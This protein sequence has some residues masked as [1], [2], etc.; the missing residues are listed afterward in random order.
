[1]VHRAVHPVPAENLLNS[2]VVSL[3]LLAPGYVLCFLYYWS[4]GYLQVDD[5]FIYLRIAH[6]MMVGLGPVWNSGDAFTN[7]T[8][9]LWPSLI[10]VCGSVFGAAKLPIISKSLFYLC[11]CGAS[12]FLYLLLK[13]SKAN[14]LAWIA[15]LAIFLPGQ[16]I[17]VIGMETALALLTVLGAIWAYTSNRSLYLTAIFLGLFYLTRAEGI[18]F[19]TL[20]VADY[21][22]FGWY[23]RRREDTARERLIA[24]M[25][26]GL[27]CLGLAA[28]WHVY[29][30]AFTGT[31]F[32]AT[33][34]A[35]MIQGASG[36]FWEPFAT[37]IVSNAL[38]A[39]RRNPFIVVLAVFGAGWLLRATPLIAWWTAIHLC[40]YGA[41]QVAAYGWYYYPLFF[42]MTLA[43]FLGFGQV[44]SS[45]LRFVQD[46][47]ASKKLLEATFTLLA[48]IAL[49][50]LT[51]KSQT[52]IAHPLAW[53]KDLRLHG[54][55]DPA[56]DRRRAY[57]QVSEWF[58]KDR[59][60]TRGAAILTDEIGVLGYH[61]REW[62]IVDEIGLTDPGFTNA[63]I[64]DWDYYVGHFAPQFL[65]RNYIANQPLI[66]N[67]NVRGERYVS[68]RKVF[69]ADSPFPSQIYERQFEY[70]VMVPRGFAK[71][72]E[73]VSKSHYESADFGY[74][75][76]E[77]YRNIDHPDLYAFVNTIMPK[78]VLPTPYEVFEHFVRDGTE[79]I[80]TGAMPLTRTDEWRPGQVIRHVSI[81]ELAHGRYEYFVGL[82]DRNAR[83]RLHLPGTGDDRV[84]VGVFHLGE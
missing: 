63:R 5:A 48:A 84:R 45:A 32:P 38:D 34:N 22:G 3:V 9:G 81:H 82:Y 18:L 65:V 52:A 71:R 46:A 36:T 66:L 29:T 21:L 24:L 33:L 54:F 62:K 6:N 79:F 69:T 80:P 25:G 11:L 14:H 83:E 47:S 13:G 72:P 77:I 53:L 61:L 2:K 12:A 64:H 75:G 70:G 55:P 1:M 57:E 78:K 50:V 40:A 28:S 43:M 7:S 19:A 58:L 4:Q 73:K 15:P 49:T 37:K 35:K 30:L 10:A 42:A 20:L 16:L 60:E 39:V 26:P 76:F 44:P 51:I 59:P 56:D 74:L 8:S 41:L 67:F 68:Y 23:R 27:A 17:F 31:F